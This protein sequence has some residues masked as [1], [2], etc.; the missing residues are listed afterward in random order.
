M[1]EK[2]LQALGF[3]KAGFINELCHEV[4]NEMTF[5]VPNL[6]KATPK[7]VIAAFFDEVYKNGVSAGKALK[8]SEIK[9]VLN[10]EEHSGCSCGPHN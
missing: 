3:Y 6:K 1:T 10:I 4:D 8:A 7:T 2:Q 9:T 5:R